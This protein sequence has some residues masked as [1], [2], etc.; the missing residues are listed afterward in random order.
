MAM[1]SAMVG[2]RAPNF[3]LLCTNGPG[4]VRKRV[5]LDD[6]LDRWLMLLFYPRDFSLI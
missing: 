4:S 5:S 3:S 1:R 6:Y 2:T